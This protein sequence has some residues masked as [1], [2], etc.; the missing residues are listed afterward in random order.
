MSALGENLIRAGDYLV[1]AETGEVVGHL[2]ADH[3]WQPTSTEDVDWILGLFLEEET[4]I[5][6]RERQKQAILANLTA[7][8]AAHERR[9]DWLRRRFAGS[10]EQFARE[11]LDGKKT[12]SLRFAHGALRFRM[13]RPK[14]VVHDEKLALVWAKEHLPAAVAVSERLLVADLPDGVPGV[15]LVPASEKFVIDSGSS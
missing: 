11:Q 12:R 2:R 5:Y 10:L 8:Q 4:G 14:R 15:E 3:D 13:T 7:I 1:D 9:L 6:A